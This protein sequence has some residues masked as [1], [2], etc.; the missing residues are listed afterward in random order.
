MDSSS[1]VCSSL[2]SS[3][4]SSLDSSFDPPVTSSSVASVLSSAGADVRIGTSAP[5]AA[6]APTL[7]LATATPSTALPVIVCKKVVSAGVM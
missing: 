4:D 5:A 7:M 2:D 6:A 1:S 3:D